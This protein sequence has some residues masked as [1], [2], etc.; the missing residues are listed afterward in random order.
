MVMKVKDIELSKMSIS[1]PRKL[2]FGGSMA[3]INYN[4]NMG[5]FH[6][7]A[8]EVDITF[9]MSYFS[10]DEK[11]G[12]WS[13]KASFND[14]DNKKQKEFYDFLCNM[15]EFLK[16]KALEN[17]VQWFK[18]KKS[19]DAIESLYNPMVKIHMDPETGEPSGKFPPSF[20]FK[21]VKKNQKIECDIYDN[22][23]VTF[24]INHLTD[25]PMKIENL[26]RKGSKVKLLLK[27]NGIWLANGKFGCTWKAE[28]VCVQV[29]EDSINEFAIISD[30]DE[31]IDTDD[32]KKIVDDSSDEEVMEPKPPTEA[33]KKTRK[34]KVKTSSN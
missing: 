23:K 26:I 11:S 18:G 24:D 27:C 3:F 10:D 2:D 20:S 33:P 21:I 29:P 22:N 8:P 17:S 31:D 4:G 6:I 28:Q 12:K 32:D 30:S 25:N 13:I 19:K 16:E 7:Q 34:V 15:D 5:P 9:D 14:L 1:N